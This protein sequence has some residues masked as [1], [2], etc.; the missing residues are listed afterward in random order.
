MMLLSLKR[1]AVT[2]LVL[3]SGLSQAT[4]LQEAQ[5]NPN[6]QA[7]LAVNSQAPMSTLT[8]AAS[9]LQALYQQHPD[10]HIAKMFYGYAQLF[11]ATD[12]LAKKNYMR[13][14][15]TSKL[16]FF[17]ID[18]AAESEENDWQMRFLRVRMDAFVPASHGRCV[19]A[20]KDLDYLQQNPAVPADL[21]PMITLMSAHALASC[22]RVADAKAAWAALA[23]QGAEGKR[24][25]EQSTAPEWTPA[26]LSAIIQPLAE[27]PL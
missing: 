21:K 16:G 23:Q 18:E 6:L 25:S 8:R 12:F 9:Q 20:L 10:R 3:V 14:A 19:V 11:M 5:D 26:E 1:Y 27:V 24:L 22:Q 13:A 2:L 17:Y 15:E 7:I 4:G